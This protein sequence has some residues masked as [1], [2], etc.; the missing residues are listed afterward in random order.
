MNTEKKPLKKTLQETAAKTIRK[1]AAKKSDLQT[2]AKKLKAGEK[3]EFL[4]YQKYS[5]KDDMMLHGKRLESNLD[6]E[7]LTDQSINMKLSKS[8]TDS[9]EVVEGAEDELRPMA[10]IESDII[11]EDIQVFG[12]KDLSMDMGDDEQLKHRNRPVDFS[13][14]D[15]DIPSSELGDREALGSEDEENNG[16]SF[17]GD[18]HEDLEEP[19]HNV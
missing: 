6:N 4:G 2:L 19:G 1:H 12:P 3:K 18:N 5:A 7:V 15:P 10:K 14:E 11:T 13:N 16:Y 8:Y 9:D 17:G